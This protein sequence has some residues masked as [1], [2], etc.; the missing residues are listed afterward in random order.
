VTSGYSNISNLPEK[1]AGIL[2]KP[3]EAAQLLNVLQTS[4]TDAAPPED[5]S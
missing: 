3:V 5:G 1:V 2:Q 4:K